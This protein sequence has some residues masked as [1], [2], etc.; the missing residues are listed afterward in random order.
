MRLRITVSHPDE[1]YIWEILNRFVQLLPK[2]ARVTMLVELGE[3]E[4]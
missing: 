3:G 1:G 2:E 4:E